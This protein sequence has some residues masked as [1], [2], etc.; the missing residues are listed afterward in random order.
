VHWSTGE[1]EAARSADGGET[2]VAASSLTIRTEPFSVESLMARLRQEIPDVPVAESEL[3]N[4]ADAYYYTRRGHQ[5]RVAA[6][7]VLRVK[8]EDPDE[9]WFYIDP[10]RSEVV[11]T[12]HRQGRIHRWLYNGL[13]SF[14]FGAWYYHWTWDATLIVLSIGGLVSSGAG[15][16]L[17]FG[18]LRRRLRRL[19]GSTIT[20]QPSGA[21]QTRTA[22]SV[23]Q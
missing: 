3:L 2:L 18:R 23:K 11:E 19:A 13:H 16:Y 10:A 14:D 12:I 6:L 5:P 20:V 22:H 1:G 8:F 15:M 4:E 17:G 21:P 9:T 7:P